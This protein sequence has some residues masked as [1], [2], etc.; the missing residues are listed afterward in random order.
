MTVTFDNL[1][2]AGAVDYSAALCADGPVKIERALNAPSI[3]AGMLDVAVQGLAVPV[4]RARVVVTAESGTV[5]FTGYLATEP[6]A[7]Y[8]GVGTTGPVYRYEWS[9][10]SD[11]WLLDRQAVPLLGAGLAQPAGGVLTALTERVAAGVVSTAGIAAGQ[12]VGVFEP[13]HA[14]SWS[15]LAGDVAGS[16]YAAY[17]VVGGAL[18]LQ[19]AGTVTH[20][21]NPGDGSMQVSALKVAAVREL[22]NDVTLSG[23]ME[24]TAYVTEIFEGDGTT[25]VFQL[26]EP[27]FRPKRTQNSTRL[28][29]ESFNEAAFNPQVWRVSDPG[30]HLSMTSAG[31]TLSGGNGLDGQTTLTAFDAV[32]IGGALVVEAGG[33]RLKAASVGVVCGLYQGA[34]SRTSCFAGYNVRQSGGSTVIAPMV[35]GAEVGTVFPLVD[36]HS[37]TLRIRLHCAEM[38]RV[39]QRYYAMVDGVVEKFGGGVV[40][41]PMDLVFEVRDEG[42]ASNTMVTVLYDGSVASSP[43]QCSFA[44]V[45]SVQLVGSIGYCRLTQTG[46]AWVTSVL[47]SGVKA[48]RL[49]G[50]AGEG[51]DCRISATGK[52]TFFAGRVPVAG[53]RVTVTHRT[54]R[55]AVARLAD[56][57]S[58]A[59]EAAGGAPGSARWLGRVTKPVARSSADCESAATAVLQFA[60]SRAA[61]VSGTYAAVNPEDMWPGDVLALPGAVNAVIRRV[62]IEDGHALPEALTYKVAFA[63]DWSANGGAEALGCGLSEAVATD[64]LLPQTAVDVSA[65]SSAVLGNLQQMQVVSVTN[66]AL[67]VDAGVDPPAGGG[68]EVRRRDWSFGLGVD[69][70]LVL[71]SPM[72]SFSIP[73]TAQVE[74]YFVRMYDGSTPARYSRFSSAVF[75]DVAFG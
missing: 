74:Q 68:F 22:A 13:G 59:Q 26:A 73:R 38:Q 34:V 47:P 67:Q 66:T 10:V 55:R 70:D 36:G 6:V 11:E 44:L 39:G 15:A 50:V 18:M 9:A 24:P 58:V 54:R 20:A 69:Q 21:V 12:P 51:V 75:T 48:T 30:S 14:A 3:C 29:T 19:P 25:T 4:R 57:A 52:V 60:T 17:R 65:V 28:L 5:L 2:G 8:A 62:T 32:E 16:T 42:V 23:E 7:V 46:S 45:N 53:E 61:A 40:A 27:P 72:R 64:A 43:A 35:N 63:N 49:V 41:A 1:D 33:V 37:Y 56:G 71:R 31:L